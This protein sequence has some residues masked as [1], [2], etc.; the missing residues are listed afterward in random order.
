MFFTYEEAKTVIAAFAV[1]SSE[2]ISPSLDAKV[3]ENNELKV[4]DKLI[5]EYPSL[6]EEYGY[7]SKEYDKY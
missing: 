5:K 2:G 4:F 1:C 6:I 3:A 7:L